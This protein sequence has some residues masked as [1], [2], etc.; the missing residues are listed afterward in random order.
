ME[1]GLHTAIEVK[2]NVETKLD[3]DGMAVISL[4]NY[5]RLYNKCSGMSG[6][7]MTI[8]EELEQV[9]GLHSVSIPTHA[10][11]IRT[12]LSLKVYKTKTAKD[13][14]IVSEIRSLNEK[15]RSVLVGSIS[16]K[17]AHEVSQ[18]LINENISHIVLDAKSEEKEAIVISQAGMESSI[19]LSASM[20]G[21]GT[22]F[23]LSSL[24]KELGGLAVIGTDLF[25]SSRVDKQLK[26]RSGRQ[27]DRNFSIFLFS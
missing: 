16:I 23:I 21:R 9:Y 2:E 15:K 7:I 10:P 12:D 26:G 1:H 24:S 13:K 18:L 4:K 20:A 3:F 14:A 6:T 27:G 19:T 25:E 22:D 5:F 17:R 8:S 11:Q